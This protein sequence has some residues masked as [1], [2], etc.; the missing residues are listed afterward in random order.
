MVRSLPKEVFC[1]GAQGVLESVEPLSAREY[2]RQRATTFAKAA[3]LLRRGITA[4]T[5]REVVRDV[6]DLPR[7]QVYERVQAVEAHVAREE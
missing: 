1:G 7:N 6:T 4:R 5:A 3:A 2:A